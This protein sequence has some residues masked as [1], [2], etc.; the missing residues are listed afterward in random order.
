LSTGLYREIFMRKASLIAPLLVLL[1]I[2][3]AAAGEDRYTLE[4]TA[5]GFVRMDRTTGE[6]SIC[7]QQA[8]QLVCRLAADERSAFEGEIDRLDDSVK[9]LEARVAKLENS[10]AVRLESALPS[11]EEFARTMGYMERFLRGF[12]DIVKDLDQE[13]DDPAKLSVPQK[14]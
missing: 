11:E 13:S 12:M 1:T 6:M 5:D 3:T 8:E 10:A 9:A 4:K 7:R 2:G 14:T